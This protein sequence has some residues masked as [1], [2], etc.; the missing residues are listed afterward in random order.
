MTVSAK[1]SLVHTKFNYSC[2]Y[3]IAIHTPC[4]LWPDSSDLLFWRVDLQPCTHWHQWSIPIGC[5][6]PGILPLTR[7][8]PLQ[9]SCVVRIICG[10]PSTLCVT[11]G[12]FLFPPHPPPHPPNSPPCNAGLN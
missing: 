6:Q 8:M 2:V 12:A 7:M 9:P 5:Y 3:S 11:W 10:Q 1:T 4:F